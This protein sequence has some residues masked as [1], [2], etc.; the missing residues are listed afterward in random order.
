MATWHGK[1][2]GTVLGLRIYVFFIKTFGLYF[3]Y[4]VL[5]F[6]AAYF[7]FFSFTSTKAT[8]F[9]FKRRLG[10]SSFS[11]ALNVYRSYFTFGMIQLDRVA[12]ASGLQHKYT[13]EFDGIDYI[14]KVL[15]KKKGGILLTAQ[16]GNFNLARHFLD[17]QHNPA[18][19]Q[20]VM[21]DFEHK[22]IKK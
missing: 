11:A 20:L 7:I 22:Q 15:Q 4:F 1:S 5:L 13:F 2:R 10:Y 19:V 14:K 6:V 18:V 17:N 9:F 3:S 16:I 12:I 8:Y 21:T